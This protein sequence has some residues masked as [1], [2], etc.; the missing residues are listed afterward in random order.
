MGVDCVW[1]CLQPNDLSPKVEGRTIYYHIA[2]DNG[3]V[4]DEGVQGYSLIF[5]GNG[6]EELTRKFEEETGLEG[7]IVCNRSPLNGKLYPLRLQL[8]PNTVTMRVVLVLPMSNCEFSFLFLLVEF[9][10]LLDAHLLITCL[11]CKIVYPK[12]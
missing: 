11:A 6:V 4:L 2:E 7:I 9:F 12:F 1:F 5:K 8:P 10:L 3:E